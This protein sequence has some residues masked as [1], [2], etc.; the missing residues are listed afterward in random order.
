[1][2][3]NELN[4]KIRPMINLLIVGAIGAV[5]SNL[6][7]LGE[8]V[9]NR[10]LMPLMPMLFGGTALTLFSTFIY[11]VITIASETDTKSRKITLWVMVL[12]L[13]V[14]YVFLYFAFGSEGID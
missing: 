2:K 13:V 6:F 5:L 11:G 8:D 14:A 4:P 9:T 1:M 7:S 12:T 3:Y 10:F